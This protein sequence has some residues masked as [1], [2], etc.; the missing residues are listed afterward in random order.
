VGVRARTR[1][2]TGRLWN[3]SLCFIIFLL[4]RGNALGCFLLNFAKALGIGR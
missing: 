2:R 1:A 3:T 4:S